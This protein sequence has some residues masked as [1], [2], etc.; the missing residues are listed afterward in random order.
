MS[1]ET[2]IIIIIIISLFFISTST[3]FGI[4]HLI[5]G[6]VCEEKGYDNYRR[7]NHKDYCVLEGKSYQV[8]MKCE[9]LINIKCVIV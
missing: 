2:M 1:D 6:G 4:E 8:N 3:Y 9:G 5:K 7:N